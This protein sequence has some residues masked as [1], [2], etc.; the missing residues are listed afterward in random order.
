MR[1]C[2]R[3]HARMRARGLH[4]WFSGVEC[5]GGGTARRTIVGRGGLGTRIILF[6]YRRSDYNSYCNM[7]SGEYNRDGHNRHDAPSGLANL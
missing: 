6:A 3:A 2:T 1:A 5:C 7:S 4:D